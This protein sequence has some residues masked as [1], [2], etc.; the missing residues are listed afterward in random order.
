MVSFKLLQEVKVSVITIRKRKFLDI[1]ILT[2]NITTFEAN[3]D[4]L[5][6]I[7]L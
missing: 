7:E 4:Y 3:S 5:Y 6:R 1:F 2:A